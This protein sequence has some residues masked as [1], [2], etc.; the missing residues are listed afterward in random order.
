VADWWAGEAYGAR[1]FL[2]LFPLFTLGLAMWL[3]RPARV[4]VWYARVAAL[5]VFTVLNGL[6]LLQYQIYMKGLPALAPYPKGWFNLYVERFIVPWRLVEW[7][8]R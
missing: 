4:T 8:L 5:A 3:D 7:L 2:S 1:R 6:L